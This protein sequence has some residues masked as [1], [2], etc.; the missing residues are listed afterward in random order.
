VTFVP[1]PKALAVVDPGTQTGAAKVPAAVAVDA[2]GK[3]E[4]A[5][6]RVSAVN[7]SN[8]QHTAA[9]SGVAGG[10]AELSL[11][12][13][14]QEL[15]AG[16]RRRLMMLMK[17]DASLGLV[18]ATLRFDPRVVAVRSVAAS[19]M[20]GDKSTTP[21]VMHS[22]DAANGVLVVS[23]APAAGAQPLSGEGMLFF[24]E[25]EGLAAGAGDI[26]FEAGKVHLIA[27]DGRTVSLT[28]APA[29]LRVTQ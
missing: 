12:P 11:V 24:V 14:Q 10:K 23:V 7:V 9:S 1:A 26:T 3:S 25:V 28:A 18:A 2:A 16:E 22:I 17:T 21:T 19:S 5:A 27:T 6:P 15:K 4:P 13:E 29:R 20:G 8:V